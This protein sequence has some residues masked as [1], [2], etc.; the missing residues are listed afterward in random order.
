MALGFFDFDFGIRDWGIGKL[1]LELLILVLLFWISDVRI[2][3]L[4]YEMWNSGFGTCEGV[5][6]EPPKVSPLAIYVFEIQLGGT[7]KEFWETRLG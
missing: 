7:L 6:G 5:L 4:G 1:D 2:W 3:N